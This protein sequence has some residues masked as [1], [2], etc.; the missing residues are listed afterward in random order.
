MPSVRW[1]PIL[2][3]TRAAMNYATPKVGYA[4]GMHQLVDLQ[5]GRLNAAQTRTHTRVN[6]ITSITGG[7]WIGL[8]DFLLHTGVLR[9]P[10]H[11]LPI[12]RRIRGCNGSLCLAASAWIRVHLRFPDQARGAAEPRS[13][14]VEPGATF[15]RDR[16]GQIPRRPRRA[17]RKQGAKRFSAPTTACTGND[18]RNH[19]IVQKAGGTRTVLASSVTFARE[20]RR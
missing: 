15:G 19:R 6:E 5:R 14:A 20:P 7:R 1:S 3:S 10:S 9:G 17:R 8:R 12:A 11:P 13:D 16:T 4:D 2:R 18:A